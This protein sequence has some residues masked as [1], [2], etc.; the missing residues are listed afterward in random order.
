MSHQPDGCA[1]LPTK[2]QF[3]AW[4]CRCGLAYRE[5]G[6]V[7]FYRNGGDGLFDAYMEGAMQ[8]R[9]AD[10]LAVVS[11]MNA[12]AA[13]PRELPYRLEHEKEPKR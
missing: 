11:Y 10:A 13:T 5:Y 2:E 8:Q 1:K 7:W 6:K 9:G 3:D 12:I 4:A